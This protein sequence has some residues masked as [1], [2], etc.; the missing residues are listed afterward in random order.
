MPMP[1]I[2]VGLPRTVGRAGEV[3]EGVERRSQEVRRDVDAISFEQASVQDSMVDAVDPDG[4]PGGGALAWFT[5]LSMRSVTPVGSG[6][7]C[8]T[9]LDRPLRDRRHRKRREPSQSRRR[10]EVRRGPR[11]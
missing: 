11:R 9:Q 8:T 2:T 5:A 6:P 10:R 4:L 3:V 7:S 1:A